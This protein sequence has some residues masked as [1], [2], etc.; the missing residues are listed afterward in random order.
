[1]QENLVAIEKKAMAH[2][3]DYK[4]KKEMALK[5][6]RYRSSIYRNERTPENVKTTTGPELNILVRGYSYYY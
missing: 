4:H 2:Q 3:A 1:M 6:G 5:A